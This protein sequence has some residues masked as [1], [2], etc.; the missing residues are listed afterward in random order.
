MKKLNVKEAN[1]KI[2]TL[3]FHIGALQGSFPKVLSNQEYGNAHLVI[4]R[5]VLPYMVHVLKFSADMLPVI[6]R[7]V[8]LANQ[9]ASHLGDVSSNLRTINNTAEMAVTEIL[10]ALDGVED[11]LQKVREAAGKGEDVEE[12]LDDV[13]MELTTV[14]SALQFQDITSQQ[15]EATHAVLAELANGLSSL[16]GYLGIAA[17]EASIE[18]KE[19]TYDT[20]ASFDRDRASDKQAEIDSMIEGGAEVDEEAEEEVEEVEETEDEEAAA[21]GSNGHVE[22][23]GEE[24]VSQEDIDALID[25]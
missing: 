18:V 2:R 22:D 20:E 3:I 19:G 12:V 21:S 10:E 1:K 11:R 7:A 4:L 23:G 24:A 5:E 17:D 25:G 14:M 16:V 6:N 9:G 15:I 13:S 8:G